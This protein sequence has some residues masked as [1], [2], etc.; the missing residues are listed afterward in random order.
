M[1]KSKKTRFTQPKTYAEDFA[2]Y[3]R[4]VGAYKR[5]E[6]D[7]KEVQKQYKRLA[8]LT[9]KRMLR[10]ER[11]AKQGQLAK[12]A[13]E[14]GSRGYKGALTR[15]I[16]KLP[17]TDVLK[18]T[19]ATVASFAGVTGYAYAE[20][21][22]MMQR[23]GLNK[24]N[25]KNLTIEQMNKAINAM[26]AFNEK[27]SATKRGI[28]NV[29]D[30]KLNSLNKTLGDTSLTWQDL[31]MFFSSPLYEKLK[32]LGY[33]SGTGFIFYD[34][35]KTIRD[36]AKMIKDVKSN[37]KRFHIGDA[38]QDNLINKAIKDGIFDDLL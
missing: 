2:A 26:Q 5:G 24:F 27:P 25:K 20:A 32:S 9:D 35:L 7:I 17:I 15:Y 21:R 13:L 34:R 29:Y 38:V 10:L 23:L 16:N 30:R 6:A 3:R 31:T 11:Y 4:T 19:L 28:E 33:D 18:G 1:V 14:T 22:D 8:D 12:R 36:P 37:S